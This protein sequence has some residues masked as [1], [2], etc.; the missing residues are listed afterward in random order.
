[1]WVSFFMQI[2]DFE[3]PLQRLRTDTEKLKC[4]RRKTKTMIRYRRN[5]NFG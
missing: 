5:A 4:I 2:N 1:M 3:L